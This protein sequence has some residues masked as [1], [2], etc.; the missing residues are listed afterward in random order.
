MKTLRNILFCLSFAV[1][2]LAQTAPTEAQM[3]SQIAAS[4][5]SNPVN[6][7]TALV[8]RELMYKMVDFIKG[9][10]NGV[11]SDSL[12]TTNYIPYFKT[13]GL[14][15]N[16]PLRISSTYLGLKTP[17]SSAALLSIEAHSSGSTP[18]PYA[19][20]LR[21]GAKDYLGVK[22][23][24]IDFDGGNGDA[25]NGSISNL[26]GSMLISAAKEVSGFGVDSLS[27]SGGKG[28]FIRSAT[29]PIRFSTGAGNG[30]SRI[31]ITPAGNVGIGIIS[32]T[33]KLHVAGNLLSSGNLIASGHISTAATGHLLYSNEIRGKISDTT[34]VKTLS[35][36]NKITHSIGAINKEQVRLNLTGYSGDAS[37]DT[38]FSVSG[39]E[40]LMLISTKGNL[41]INPSTFL[42][43]DVGIGT[44]SPG[45]KLEVAGTIGSSQG[46][47]FAIGSGNVGIS[48]GSPSSK[49]HV[50]GL[51]EYANNSAAVSGGLTV[52]AFYHT[53]GVLKVVIP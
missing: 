42:M 46:A 21:L 49:L 45:Y 41:K 16:S 24:G 32:A 31:N 27:M 36:A 13:T 6:K 5:P 38:L 34:V 25:A 1:A 39:D 40:D 50:V 47:N 22:S 28:V 51:P 52:G 2:A 4:L 26:D 48:T 53:A 3:R 12:A 23:S 7:I 10:A 43:G 11:F 37:E 14:L 8:H 29:G 9:G 35:S 20:N 17:A 19:H 18:N 33:E 44:L 15:A 30:T